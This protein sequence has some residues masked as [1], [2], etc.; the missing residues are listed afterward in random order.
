MSYAGLSICVTHLES[1]LRNSSA[2]KT[3]EGGLVTDQLKAELIVAT[4]LGKNL[5]SLC[6]GTS[7]I[8]SISPLRLDN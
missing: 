4:P 8:T 7:D 2:S 5:A 3:C 1:T 6:I